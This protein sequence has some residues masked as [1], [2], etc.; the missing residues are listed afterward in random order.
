MTR[1]ELISD[2]REI[3][4]DHS[5]DSEISDRSILFQIRTKRAKYLRQREDR[6]RFEYRDQFYQTVYMDLEI[7]GDTEITSLTTGGT[8]LRTVKALPNIIGREIYDHLKVRTADGTRIE[9]IS[10]S[11]ADYLKGAP[12]GFIYCFKRDDGKLQLEG[13]DAVYKNLTKLS[14]QAI[15]EDPEDIVDLNDLTTHLTDYPITGELWEIIKSEIVNLFL[16]SKNIPIDTLN[17]DADDTKV[18]Q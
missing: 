2:I 10:K 7:V 1:A 6:E 15:L 4:R 18:S 8:T 9:V 12:D 14:V 16:T 17:N 13:K 11:R 3:L 5:I